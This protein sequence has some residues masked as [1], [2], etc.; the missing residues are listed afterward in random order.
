MPPISPSETEVLP[1]P[2]AA[3]GPEPQRAAAEGPLPI[4]G[5]EWR[6]DG[7][8]LLSYLLDSE[9]HTF[10]F[11]VSANAILSFIPFIVMLY[12]IA[13]S[14]F[15]SPAMAAVIGDMVKYF[16]P[17]NQDWVAQNLALVADH[18][19][20][21][22]FSLIAILVSCTGIFLPLEV[23]LNRSWGVAHSRNYLMNQLVALGLAIWMVILGMG[24]IFIN[25]GERKILTVIFWGHV[26]NVAFHFLSDSWLAIST[27][28]ASILF[29]F[30]IYWLLPN[31]KVPV[32][33]VIRVA[34]VT[35]LLWVGAKY[36]FVAVL[37]RLDLR[38][39]YGP[40]YVSV[41][42]LLW[43]YVSGLLLFAGAQFSAMRHNS[44]NRP[45]AAA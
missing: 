44:R 23:A 35:G 40:F 15:H 34:I 16:F 26:D 31:R 38:A 13:H 41:G 10:A 27:A 24:S 12:T 25:Q 3:R 19:G 14:I 42:L 39:L 22:A 6:R 29:F 43:A 9:V 30:S 28:I 7:K 5:F 17:S 4:Y 33:P 37:P 1:E 36:L 45:G 8:T 20:V 32:R 2:G 18:K 11:S 21:R